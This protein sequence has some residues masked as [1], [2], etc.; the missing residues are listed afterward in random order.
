[1]Q[2]K[3]KFLLPLVTGHQ[4]LAAAERDYGAGVV[5]GAGFGVATFRSFTLKI[6]VEFD[7]IVPT[8][9]APY[10]SDGGIASKRSP[11]TFIPLTPTWK[12]GIIPCTPSMKT[13]GALPTLLS[14]TV[15][16]V[17]FPVYSTVTSIPGLASSPV[18]TV[19]SCPCTC[20]GGV[21]VPAARASVGAADF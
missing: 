16:S 2:S 13:S 18:P 19:T 5:A 11:P 7:G 3:R 9:C 20:S 12:P 10:P 4:K 21:V 15:P 1:M 6:S 17:S 8:C 14:N